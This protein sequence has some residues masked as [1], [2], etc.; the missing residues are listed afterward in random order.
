MAHQTG[1]ASSLLPTSPFYWSSRFATR[2]VCTASLRLAP[3]IQRHLVHPGSICSCSQAGLL[4]PAP[5]PA[6]APPSTLLGSAVISGISPQG[7]GSAVARPCWV[8]RLVAQ[9]LCLL[10]S[11]S[12]CSRSQSGLLLPAPLPAPPPPLVGIGSCIASFGLYL[13][14]VWSAFFHNNNNHNHN[15][16]RRR[17][18][19]IKERRT[20]DI[21]ER[22]TSYIA[23]QRQ[24]Q[25]PSH[26]THSRITIS[27]LLHTIL[28]CQK[29]RHYLRPGGLR[30]KLAL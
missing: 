5:I 13:C 18:S 15:Q 6:P 10:H 24:L 12:K 28:V 17:T 20:S 29:C 11:G 3:Y 23:T 27:S 21:K 25:P 26:T 2:L 16:A 19:D 7:P 22:R 8:A 4:L 9:L 1:R 30:C 14:L